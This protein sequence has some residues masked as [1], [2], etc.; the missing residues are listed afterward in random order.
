MDSYVTGGTIRM[1]REKKG[2]TQKQLAERLFVSDKTVSKWEMG[3]GLPD[4][5]LLEPLARALG[6][7]VAELISGDCAVNRN[8]GGN[9]ARMRFY[10]CP[11]CGNILWSV[12]EGAFS[13]CGVSLPPLEP[14]EP[15]GDHRIQVERVEDEWY[16][17]L[18][19]PMT[20]DHYLSFMAY[21]TTDRV[22]LRKLYPEQSAESRFPMA[23]HGT[24][25]V[26]CNHHGL[27]QTRI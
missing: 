4:I 12:G 21:V 6:V 15:D 16:V 5:T 9:M 1:L 18:A 13:C 2:Y 14:E 19:H 10:V 27:Y 23:G 24:L 11:V 7:S 17:T 22:T 8:R 3:K 26:Y 20:K 25:Y